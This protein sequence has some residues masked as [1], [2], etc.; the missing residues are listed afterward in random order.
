MTVENIM[1]KKRKDK[2]SQSEI[3]VRSS[4]QNLQGAGKVT[5]E[6]MNNVLECLGQDPFGATAVLGVVVGIASSIYDQV[7]L[8]KSNKERAKLLSKR[9]NGILLNSMSSVNI[10]KKYLILLY[11]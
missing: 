1:M 7:Q 2:V 5:L 8:L 6:M 4:E 11:T 10:Y 9:V 3:R